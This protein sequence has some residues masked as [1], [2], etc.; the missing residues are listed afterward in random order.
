MISREAFSNQ[1]SAFSPDN[2]TAED[3]EN[4]EGR[5]RERSFFYLCQLRDLCG[6]GLKKVFV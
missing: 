4:A 3:A 5:I 1:Y 6:S 2:F